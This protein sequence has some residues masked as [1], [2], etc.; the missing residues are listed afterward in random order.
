V[1]YD[2]RVYKFNA[3]NNAVVKINSINCIQLNIMQDN[4]TS[5]VGKERELLGYN[6][7]DTPTWYVRNETVT[8][9]VASWLSSD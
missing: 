1:I 2:W 8:A 6:R 3:Y 7:S 5:D 9:S 4:F